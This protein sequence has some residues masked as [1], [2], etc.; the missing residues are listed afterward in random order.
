MKTAA[1]LAIASLFLIAAIP[2][3][4]RTDRFE[5]IWNIKVSPDDQGRGWDDQ[6][7]FKG[8]QFSSKTMAAKGFGP[9]MYE[10][11]TRGVQMNTFTATAKSNKEGKMEWS[12]LTA[13]GDEIKGEIKW[14]KSNGDVANYTYT[15]TIIPKS[16]EH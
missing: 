16:W 6:I 12:G 15:G 7:T 14:T 11:D 10:S 5:G 8:Q 1:L 2:L 13:V 3:Q 9:T 4:R